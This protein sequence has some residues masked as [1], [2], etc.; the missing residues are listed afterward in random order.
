MSTSEE[1]ISTSKQNVNPSGQADGAQPR[2]Q[3][4]KAERRELQERQRAAKAA[5]AAS[6]SATQ[7]T[8]KPPQN[9]AQKPPKKEPSTHA[10]ASG[11]PST[12]GAG[13]RTGVRGGK[14][15]DHIT[16][17]VPGQEKYDKIGEGAAQR[18]PQTQIFA[19]FAVPKKDGPIGAGIKGEI[20]PAIVRLG[21][22][23]AD[24]KIVGANARCIAMLVAFKAVIQDYITPPNL[25]LARD[26]AQ[27]LSPQISYLVSA[28]PMAVSMGNAIREL[29]Y[30]ISVVSIDLPEQDAKDHLCEQ[31]DTYISHRIILADTVIEEYAMP[32]IQN[33]AVIMTYARSSV[34][35][36][37][38]IA[39]WSRGKRFS[40]KVVDSAPLFEGKHLLAALLKAGIPCT[41]LLVNGIGSV[42]PGVSLV[43]LGAHAL[44]SNGSVYSRAGTALVAM[45]AKQHSVPV[46]VLAETYKYSNNLQLDSFTKNELG[47]SPSHRPSA[48]SV[49]EERSQQ[50]LQAINPLYDLT[51]YHHI[52]VLV[53]EVGL[54]PP[55]AISTLAGLRDKDKGFQMDV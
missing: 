45:L 33:G 38:L 6:S 32:K 2:K 37:V 5:G 28:R 44:N 31:I 15:G 41:Y 50:S 40:V 8:Q 7:K 1:P 53:T 26:L 39:A 12:S 3:M 17:G 46:L 29:K 16:S 13:K 36:R 51:P 27:H 54:I 25:T 9:Q 10:G 42:I 23:F 4:T 30:H 49:F 52:T 34:V 20:H 47:E 55:S 21:R 11:T 18:R 14:E 19:H 35:E 48:T 22:Q 43:F 24:M